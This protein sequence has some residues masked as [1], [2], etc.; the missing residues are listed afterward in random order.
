MGT[1]TAPLRRGRARARRRH[2]VQRGASS[3]CASTAAASRGVVA[4]RRATRSPPTSSS[5]NA[6]PFRMRELVGA[7]A[8]PADVQRAHRRLRAAG[9]DVQ[10]E[11]G[12]ARAC[13]SSPACPRTAASSARRSTCCPTRRT[14]C[15]RINEGFADGAARQARPSSR[16]SSGTSTR[17]SIPSLQGRRRATT[18]PR[19]SCSGCRTSSQG[20]TW[21]AEE[22]QVRASTCSRSA[23]ASRR[24]RASSSSTRSRCTRRRS[25]STSA[26]RAGTSTTSTTASASPIACPYA[27]ADRRA[28]LVQRRLPSGGQRHRRRRPQRRHA[29]H[30]GRG[31]VKLKVDFNLR[32]AGSSY[33]S[34]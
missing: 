13:R 34:S 23:I 26:S 9:H 33:A 6:D 8:L 27:H 18:T 2:R 14:S 29:R 7:R 30:Q 16:P 22:A 17:P 10:G 15:A 1:V 24:A 4:R 3:G 5:C 20:T 28:L 31:R 12:A 19:S 11:P 32:Q 25:S 21:D